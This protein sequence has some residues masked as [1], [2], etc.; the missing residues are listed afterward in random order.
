MGLFI[1]L[2]LLVAEVLNESC[3]AIMKKISYWKWENT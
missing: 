2:T 1:R 3:A